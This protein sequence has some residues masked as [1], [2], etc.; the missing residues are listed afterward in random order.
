MSSAVSAEEEEG[1]GSIGSSPSLGGAGGRGGMAV[2]GVAAILKIEKSIRISN[3]LIQGCV[4]FRDVFPSYCSLF[5]HGLWIFS[6]GG[7]G[8]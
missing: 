3:C 2:A 5:A 8:K 4:C 6:L 7:S 1:G